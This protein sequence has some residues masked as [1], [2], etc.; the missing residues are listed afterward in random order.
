MRLRAARPVLEYA[1]VC[2]AVYFA[3]PPQRT[4]PLRVAMVAAFLLVAARVWSR[5]A[6]GRRAEPV[7]RVR[8]VELPPP[9]EQQVRL[10]RL[11]ASLTY[12]SS[13]TRQFHRT[14]RPL[15]HGLVEDRLARHHGIDM[16]ASPAAARAIIGEELWQLFQTDPPA[17][18]AALD[19]PGPSPADLERL[20]AAVEAV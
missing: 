7:L 13:S 11:E 1:V 8:P 17:R 16:L 18:P 12:A 4:T 9:G 14:A 2:A 6:A 3:T 15:L 5:T 10:A 19:G 20:V